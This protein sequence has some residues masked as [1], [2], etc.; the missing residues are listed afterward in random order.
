MKLKYYLKGI[1]VGLIVATLI[2]TIAYNVGRYECAK[3]ST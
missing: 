1:G 3:Q 2:L